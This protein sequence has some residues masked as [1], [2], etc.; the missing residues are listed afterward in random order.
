MK[1][2]S[3]SLGKGN[4]KYKCLRVD[5]CQIRFRNSKEASWAGVGQANVMRL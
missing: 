5:V 1:E 2:S 4:S 3:G